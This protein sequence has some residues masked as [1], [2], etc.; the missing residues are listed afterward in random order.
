MIEPEDYIFPHETPRHQR[1][2]AEQQN[3]NNT[4]SDLK[5]LPWRPFSC[6]W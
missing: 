5:A 6:D 2:M 4:L 1:T 3:V